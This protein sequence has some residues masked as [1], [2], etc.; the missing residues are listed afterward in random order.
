MYCTFEPALDAFCS[1]LRAF[2]MPKSSHA[3]YKPKMQ[4][5]QGG[6]FYIEHF[7][8]LKICGLYTR[9]DY[10]RGIREPYLLQSRRALIKI[11]GNGLCPMNLPPT[12][13]ASIRVC[14]PIRMRASIGAETVL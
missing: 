12:S 5:M 4:I 8:A 7:S 9:A 14:G 11:Y 3:K 13:R 1:I 10:R 6:R 2:T